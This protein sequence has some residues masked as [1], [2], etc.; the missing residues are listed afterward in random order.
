[1]RDRPCR[2]IDNNHVLD[3]KGSLQEEEKLKTE[4][5]HL[6]RMSGK[7]VIGHQ[8]YRKKVLYESE[9]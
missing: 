2:Q 5:E 9:D 8:E 1:M 3:V 4:Q 7:I 6:Y